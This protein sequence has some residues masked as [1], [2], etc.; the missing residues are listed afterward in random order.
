MKFEEV[1]L[2]ALVHDVVTQFAKYSGEKGVG[3]DAESNDIEYV[4]GNKSGLV[5][6]IMNIVR[7]ALVYTPRGGSVFVSVKRTSPSFVTLEVRDTGIGIEPEKIK[8]IFEPFYQV[9]PSRSE[10]RGSSG[11]GLAIVNELVKL[12]HGKISIRS[13]LDMGTTVTVE[14]PA[15]DKAKRN[16]FKEEVPSHAPSSLDHEMHIDYTRS[17]D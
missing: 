17:R 11:L 7:N 2:G 13:T 15:V 8:K 1:D 9:S 3:L 16:L 4:W 5:Q 14:L 10:N 12:H 6:I